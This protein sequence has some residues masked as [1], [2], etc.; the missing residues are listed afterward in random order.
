MG[1][2]D[3]GALDGSPRPWF[4]GRLEIGFVGH[5]GPPPIALEPRRQGSLE[6]RDLAGGD[7]SLLQQEVDGLTSR[8][9]DDHGRRVA[10]TRVGKARAAGRVEPAPQQQ[11]LGAGK[12][13]EHGDPDRAEEEVEP[14]GPRSPSGVSG[15]GYT[16][17]AQS[18]GRKFGQSDGHGLPRLDSSRRLANGCRL[19][20]TGPRRWHRLPP[21]P[22]DR[23]RQARGPSR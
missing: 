23:A 1:G 8:G 12:W 22:S 17:Q 4:R 15:Q 14:R 19:T 20:T 11:P 10:L 5:S 16:A 7:G 3:T 2:G 13:P 21:P 9:Q 18:L 6:I